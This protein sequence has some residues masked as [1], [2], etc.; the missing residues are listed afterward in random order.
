MRRHAAWVHLPQRA[1]G[2]RAP[3]AAWPHPGKA[4]VHHRGL[5][6][7]SVAGGGTA[8]RQ[9]RLH[10]ARF[11]VTACAAAA[12]SM[13]TSTSWHRASRRRCPSHATAPMAAVLPPRRLPGRGLHRR[14]CTAGRATRCSTGGWRKAWLHLLAARDWQIPRR[15]RTAAAVLRTTGCAPRAL[16]TRASQCAAS[17]RYLSRTTSSTRRWHARC[18]TAWAC[19]ARWL[20]TGSRRCTRLSARLRVLAGAAAHLAAATAQSRRAR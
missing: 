10:R 6:P 20:P 14:F 9:L 16:R 18:C 17:A 1:C 5:A 15:R 19:I 8:Q 4:L 3:P 11:A 2:E 13:R 7:G 12:M